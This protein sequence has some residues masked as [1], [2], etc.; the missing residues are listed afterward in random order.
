MRTFR[1][2]AIIVATLMTMLAAPAANAAARPAPP[3]NLHATSVS[4][5]DIVL[6]WSRSTG[7]R[8]AINYA[9]FFD[10]NPTPFLTS[11]ATSF[12][13]HLNRAIGMV[14]GS[15]HTFRIRAQDASGASS[16]STGL[17]VA[18]APGDNTPPTVPRNL[19]VVR[20]DA[21]GVELAWDASSDRSAFDYHVAGAP[22]SPRVVP[23]SVTHVLVP[24]VASDPVCGLLPGS[25]ATFSVWARD[26]FDN[27]SGFS[28]AVTVTPAG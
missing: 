10:D 26:A 19:R 14:P 21:A 16:F 2:A 12:D 3:G 6:A 24:S 27:D 28:N 25:T 8:G 13:V 7:G 9:V 5:T 11:D 22:C 20:N 17:T 23:D 15:T 1:A 4:D 18:F